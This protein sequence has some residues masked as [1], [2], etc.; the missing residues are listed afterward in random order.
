MKVSRFVKVQPC[1]FVEAEVNPEAGHVIRRYHKF[2]RSMVEVHGPKHKSHL[3]VEKGRVGAGIGKY[4]PES[5]AVGE[6]DESHS[7]KLSAIF[8]DG[9]IQGKAFA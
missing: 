7:P 5:E 1:Q 9:P 3:K 4:E 8:I 2:G 6:S